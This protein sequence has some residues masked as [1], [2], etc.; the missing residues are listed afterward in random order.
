MIDDFAIRLVESTGEVLLDHRET[1]GVANTH[2]ERARGDFDAVGDEVLRVTRGLGV[3]LT[4]LLDVFNLRAS[5]V[6]R[7]FIVS[8]RVLS[9]SSLARPPERRSRAFASILR[10]SAR[11]LI[12]NPNLRLYPH[13]RRARS[14]IASP[15]RARRDERT[16][17]LG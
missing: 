17:T 6:H 14:R 16:E 12:Q 7:A 5:S 10:A 2:T 1:D 4:E 13:D 11:A 3:P 15:A 9:P 8:H